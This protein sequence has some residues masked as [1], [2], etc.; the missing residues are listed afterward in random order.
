MNFTPVL[1]L[2]VERNRSNIDYYSYKKANI[3]VGLE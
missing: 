2:S 1:Y 3:S